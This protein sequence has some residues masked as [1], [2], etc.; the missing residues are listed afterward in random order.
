MSVGEVI[1]LEHSVGTPI[2]VELR[3]FD[4]EIVILGGLDRDS[5][6]L[7]RNA[8]EACRILREKYGINATVDS[9]IVYWSHFT[10]AD[11]YP[12][13]IPVIIINGIEVGKGS[14][15]SRDEI[16]R[17]ALALVGLL[18]DKDYSILIGNMERNNVQEIIAQC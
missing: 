7:E 9:K 1:R 17:K 16:V 5:V 13:S 8:R 14:V 18:E 3:D 4:V 15:L 6:E 2:D 12:Y 10:I 11:I